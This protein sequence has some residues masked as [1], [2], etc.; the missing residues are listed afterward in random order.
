MPQVE[1]AH[2]EVAGVEAGDGRDESN[3]SLAERLA[4]AK[5]AQ[6]RALI[7]CPARPCCPNTMLTRTL[8]QTAAAAE[9]KQAE[10]RAKHLRKQLGEQRRE[11]SSKA[12]EAQTLAKQR[13]AAEAAVQQVSSRS[14]A[15]PMQRVSAAQLA[16]LSDLCC[17]CPAQSSTLLTQGREG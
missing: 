9:G 5:N 17:I 8:T 16:W 7:P 11:L 4:D 6:V 1:A 14:A 13:A 12:S 3:R 10:V 2:G 15:M